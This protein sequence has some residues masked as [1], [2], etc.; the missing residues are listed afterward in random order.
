MYFNHHYSLG[1][2]FVILFFGAWI[3]VTQLQDLS[4]TLVHFWVL[5]FFR[6]FSLLVFS[7]F[8]IFLTLPILFFPPLII[9]LHNWLL[10]GCLFNLASVQHGF[11]LT[12]FLSSS[13]LSNFYCLLDR[14][15]I[16][17][18]PFGFASLVFFFFVRGFK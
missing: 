11:H 13:P 18:V 6:G 2:L 16:L 7:F 15:K 5:Q 4:F 1:A 12:Y 8:G 9:L 3:R 14:I 10:W 17:G